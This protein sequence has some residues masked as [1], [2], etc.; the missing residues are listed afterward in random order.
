MHIRRARDDG[1]GTSNDDAVLPAFLYMNIGIRVRLLMWPERPVTFS[2]GHCYTKGEVLFLHLMEVGQKPGM[3]ICAVF[4]IHQVG[5][6]KKRIEPIVVKVTLHTTALTAKQTY[7]FELIDQILRRSVDV[8]HPID[9][10]ARR[11]L[12]GNHQRPVAFI[13]SKIVGQPN[14]V[15]ARCQNW[16]ICD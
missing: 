6:L 2:I 8:E 4:C 5:D 1:F 3:D 16:G 7:S 9:L 13:K 14:S 12:I 10:G 15:N 11:V